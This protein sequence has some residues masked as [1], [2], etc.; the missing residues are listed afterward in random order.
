MSNKLQNSDWM[1]CALG[2]FRS[3]PT[4]FLTSNITYSCLFSF[5]LSFPSEGLGFFLQGWTGGGIEGWLVIGRGVL[6]RD[7]NWSSGQ[8]TS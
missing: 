4:K 6:A 7:W 5:L 8:R 1:F 2:L 3:Y